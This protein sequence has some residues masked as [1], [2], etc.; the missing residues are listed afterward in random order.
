MW[1]IALMDR[2]QCMGFLLVRILCLVLISW[3]ISSDRWG[4]LSGDPYV[5]VSGSMS[6]S[7]ATPFSLFR[8]LT[9]VL[10]FSLLSLH[11]G[12]FWSFEWSGWDGSLLAFLMLVYI[13]V[14][15]PSYIFLDNNSCIFFIQSLSKNVIRILKIIMF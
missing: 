5:C 10:R 13:D 6:M 15:V 4:A 9:M 3:N 7:A 12:M 14:G 1:W 2:V 11:F 8:S